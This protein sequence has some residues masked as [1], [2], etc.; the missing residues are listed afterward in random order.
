MAPRKEVVEEEGEKK[1]RKK[2]GKR[3]TFF[4]SLSLSLS[5][6][7]ASIPIG[8]KMLGREG[9]GAEQVVCNKNHPQPHFPFLCYTAPAPPG[10]HL[11]SEPGGQGP[12]H[13]NLKITIGI[14]MDEYELACLCH[15]ENDKD[16][17]DCSR[18]YD[19]NDKRQS[20]KRIRHRF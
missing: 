13:L 9:G 4:L 5:H 18:H 20:K 16:N 11:R 6:Y 17:G 2:E 7:H 19:Q 15:C 8:T 10:Y 1:E 14:P 3:V 12:S